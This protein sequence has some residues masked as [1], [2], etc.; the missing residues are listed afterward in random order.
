MI[1]RNLQEDQ[2]PKHCTEWKTINIPSEALSH[3]QIRNRKHFGQ[4]KGTPFTRPPLLEDLGFCADTLE[5]QALLD[6]DNELGNID[7]PAMR[8]L[9]D[10]LKRL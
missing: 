3:L 7:N 10:N 6:G 9:L 1:F 2:D 4:A 5:A 8:L